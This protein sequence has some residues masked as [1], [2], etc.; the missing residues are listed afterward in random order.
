MFAI[1]V[2]PRIDVT[3]SEEPVAAG[4]DLPYWRD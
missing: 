2:D 3:T 4:A 1:A